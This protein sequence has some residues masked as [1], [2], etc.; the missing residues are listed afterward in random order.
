MKKLLLFLI[1]LA[2][3]SLAATANVHALPK[4]GTYDGNDNDWEYI[5]KIINEWNSNNMEDTSY[6]LP[7]VVDSYVKF[8]DE[9]EFSSDEEKATITWSGDYTYLSAK[10]SKKF[11]LFYIAGVSGAE[12]I[13][14]TGD[15]KH[16]LSHYVLWNPMTTTTKPVPEPTSIYL[17]GFSLIGLAVYRY[18]FSKIR[19]F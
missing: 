4:L 17:L 8:E 11:D 1:V 7:L 6:P 9:S 19:S 13:V 18:Q 10:Y 16:G 15:D 3:S 12:G 14:W 2:I 5:N